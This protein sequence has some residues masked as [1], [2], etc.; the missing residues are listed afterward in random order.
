MLSWAYLRSPQY[1][2]RRY[3]MNRRERE[4]EEAYQRGVADERASSRAREMNRL[5]HT[6]PDYLISLR[7]SLG[8]V[9]DRAYLGIDVKCY[10]GA[11]RR[12]GRIR[13]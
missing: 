9:V 5:R 8:G 4:L 11:R 7:D 1:W 12:T 3:D 13:P 6:V 2:S 10:H